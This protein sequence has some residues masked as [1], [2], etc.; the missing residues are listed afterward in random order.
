MGYSQS[1]SQGLSRP[2][3]PSPTRIPVAIP[4]KTRSPPPMHPLVFTRVDHQQ[5][6]PEVIIPRATR[7]DQS[8]NIPTA[9]INRSRSHRPDH[10]DP[11]PG[12]QRL[13]DDHHDRPRSQQRNRSTELVNERL[14]DRSGSRQGFVQ[15]FTTR[16]PSRSHSRQ[17]RAAIV[18]P[19]LY[20]QRS[21]NHPSEHRE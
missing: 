21:N 3:S 6:S 17:N 9:I 12:I 4:S 16:I 10:P 11:I 8:Q 1:H 20:L 18:A 7:F 2:S 14:P 19:S 5:T 13:R 15:R